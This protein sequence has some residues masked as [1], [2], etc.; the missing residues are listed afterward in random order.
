MLKMMT[1]RIKKVVI[2]LILSD[3]NELETAV[4]ILHLYV[5]P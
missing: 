5:V 2:I 4:T 1:N 3:I